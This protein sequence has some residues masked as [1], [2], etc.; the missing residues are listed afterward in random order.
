[1]ASTSKSNGSGLVKN[2]AAYKRK[3]SDNDN[4]ENDKRTKYWEDS[5]DEPLIPGVLVRVEVE[6]VEEPGSPLDFSAVSLNTDY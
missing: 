6:E 1:M 2:L 3:V 5:D 4:S